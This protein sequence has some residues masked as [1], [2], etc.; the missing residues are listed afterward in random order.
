ME[1]EISKW[2]LE[3]NVLM[4]VSPGDKVLH[5]SKLIVLL[6]DKLN[7]TQATKRFV[8]KLVCWYN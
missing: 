6:H 5:L 2:M 7:V 4:N 8:Q 1:M 3:L